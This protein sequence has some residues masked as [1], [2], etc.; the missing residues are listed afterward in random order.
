MG[1]AQP[2]TALRAL[3][4]EIRSAAS[5]STWERERLEE[6]SWDPLSVGSTGAA[7]ERY[8]ESR[9]EARAE[10]PTPSV[11]SAE[12][13]I[14]AEA[15]RTDDASHARPGRREVGLTAYNQDWAQRIGVDAAKTKRRYQILLAANFGW[16]AA[17]VLAVAVGAAILPP[18]S[19]NIAALIGLV[20][21]VFVFLLLSVKTARTGRRVALEASQAL[22]KVN[23]GRNLSVPSRAL[24][25]TEWF[26]AWARQSSVQWVTPSI[27]G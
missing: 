13:S 16:Y 11:A 12:S 23:P 27:Q 15:E 18:A 26:D 8:A 4:E 19:R 14:S 21:F 7:S 22:L 5:V 25:G 17:L 9:T 6:I 24:R 2:G 3:P 20:V 10:W 1:L